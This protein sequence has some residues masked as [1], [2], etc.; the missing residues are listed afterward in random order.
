[1][2]KCIEY[3]TAKELRCKGKNCCDNHFKLDPVFDVK[4]CELRKKFNLPMNP[5]S[6]ARCKAHNDK[7]RSQGGAGGRPK[8]FHIYDKPQWAG[9]E[10][11]GAIDIRYTD[12]TYRNSL[13]RLAWELGWRIGYNKTFLHLDIAAIKGILPQ[14]IFKYDSI[15][16]KELQE[17]TRQITGK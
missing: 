2:L 1:M 9:L 4:L 10:G 7:P 8:S 3:F 17:F 11:C 12:I 5:T 13:A 14:A 16:P 15:T 6:A